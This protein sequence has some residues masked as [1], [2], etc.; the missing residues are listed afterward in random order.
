MEEQ[1]IN[2]AE[3]ILNKSKR[4]LISW[5]RGN[6]D[7]TYQTALGKGVIMISFDNKEPRFDPEGN[8]YPLYSLS[9]INE[10]GETFYSIY[11]VDKDDAYYDLLDKI[12]KQAHSSY[13]KIEETLK[14]M[15]DDLMNRI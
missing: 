8:Q 10:K 5:N 2:L 15:I 11:S 12:Y 13:M 3:Q 7:D 9:F 6:Y 1:Y 4:N 14:S